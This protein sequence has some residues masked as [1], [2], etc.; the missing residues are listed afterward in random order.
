[1][2][3]LAG[4]DSMRIEPHRNFLIGRHHVLLAGYQLVRATLDPHQI[5]SSVGVLIVSEQPYFTAPRLNRLTKTK[6]ASP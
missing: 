5:S 3:P 1:M 2:P 6:A 4:R